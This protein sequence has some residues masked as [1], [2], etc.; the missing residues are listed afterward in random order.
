MPARNVV[1]GIRPERLV[2]GDPLSAMIQ[3]TVV[4]IENLGSEEIAHLVT[5]ACLTLALRGPRPLGLTT[6]TAVG[7]DV[8]VTDVHLFDAASG[9]RLAWRQQAV[10]DA[11]PLVAQHAGVMAAPDHAPV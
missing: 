10:Q 3:A 8:T 9:R 5:A 4:M 11:Q 7:L 6:G 1:L 2:R